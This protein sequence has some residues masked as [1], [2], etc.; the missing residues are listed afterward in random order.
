M[1]EL[2]AS[3]NTIYSLF[4]LELEN[5]RNGYKNF[6]FDF[7]Y[8]AIITDPTLQ[9]VAGPERVEQFFRWEHLLEYLYLLGLKYPDITKGISIDDIINWIKE[10]EYEDDL[11]RLARQIFDDFNTLSN[12]QKN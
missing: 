6:D 12:P 2:D 4:S 3:F 5:S 1:D 8:Q 7:F 10:Y 9:A 11:K